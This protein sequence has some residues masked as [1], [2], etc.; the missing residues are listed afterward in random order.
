M[1]QKR[2]GIFFAVKLFLL[3]VF[4]SC[5]NFSDDD[6]SFFDD[7][8]SYQSV[9]SVYS[10]SFDN[11]Y[12]PSVI[13]IINDQM[14]VSDQSGSPSFHILNIEED[15]S[16]NYV[17]G[18]GR[19]GEGPGEF[20]RLQDF[21]DADSLIYVYDGN[22]FKLVGF[23][24]EGYL[25]PQN[26]IHL[27]TEGLARSMY[28]V[29]EERF[30]AVGVFFHDRFQIFD[31]NG[32]LVE[33]HGN[34]I[35]FDERFTARDNAMAWLSSA[36]VHPE[37]E[38]VYTF[39][40]NADFIEKYSIDGEL[41]RLVQGSE[42]PIPNM[43]LV[44]DWP[45]DDGGIL[46][47]L[48]ADSDEDYIYALYSGDLRSEI[49]ERNGTMRTVAANKVHKLDWDLNLIDAYVLDHS[50]TIIAADGRGGIY[51]IVHAMEGV[52]IRY[53]ELD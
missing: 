27:R 40:M 44:D 16:L 12:D 33:R 35:E 51:S 11:I 38:F 15:H 45:V 19:E 37:G 23:D 8:I 30:V 2:T 7:E 18:E 14:F 28:S 4:F 53:Q 41:I 48:W 22:Q 46:A 42:I 13:R 10:S 5:G 50:T 3:L 47:Y 29:P 20:T 52:E 31:G 25:L 6:S 34:L 32:T 17:R 39:A 49:A 24:R 1:F 26:E 21:I 9:E 43:T 36:V